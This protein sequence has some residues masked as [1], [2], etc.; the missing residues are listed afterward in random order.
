MSGD[1]VEHNMLA[2]VANLTISSVLR[3]S[4][5][6]VTTEQVIQLCNVSKTCTLELLYKYV[7]FIS[8]L[9]GLAVWIL[10][11]CTFTLSIEEIL[12]SHSSASLG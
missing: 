4:I 2:A 11:V 9:Y 1:I 10:Y 5:R 3:I 12:R 7:P 8:I 6:P